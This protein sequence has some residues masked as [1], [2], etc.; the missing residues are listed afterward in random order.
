MREK[1]SVVYRFQNGFY[2]NITNRCPNLCFFCIKNKWSM[3][4]RGYN[5]G[6][7]KEP[8][9][10]EVLS[11]IKKEWQKAKFEELVFCGYG[12]PTMR[13]EVLT[14][15]AKAVKGGTLGKD[16][17]GIKIRLNTIGLGNLVNGRDITDDLKEVLDAVVISL[18]TTD[19]VQWVKIVRPDKKYESRGFESVKEF[20]ALCAGKIKNTSITAV[21]LK[22]V[23]M[24]KL[25]KY[26]QKLGI[27]F[28]IRPYL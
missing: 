20:I 6:L 22:E 3:D 5:L 9:A 10:E 27:K 24:E 18:N 12:E 8:S 15:I 7:E 4:F 13:L 25:R 28:R 17:S 11:E 21:D 19:P 16:I 1:Q 23:D 26:A 14:D 2:V